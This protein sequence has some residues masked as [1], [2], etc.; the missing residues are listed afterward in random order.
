MLRFKETALSNKKFI[1]LSIFFFC[2]CFLS[3]QLGFGKGEV[4]ISNNGGL[5]VGVKWTFPL[6]RQGTLTQGERQRII[7]EE[8][9]SLIGKP[10]KEVHKTWGSPENKSFRNK[11]QQ[12]WVYSLKTKEGEYNQIYFYFDKKNNVEKIQIEHLK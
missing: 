8:S 5:F 6:G 7:L 3:T 9:N 1:F 12:I 4:E 2:L 10:Q 11:K